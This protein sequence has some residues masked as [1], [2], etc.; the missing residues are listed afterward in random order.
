VLIRHA[1]EEEHRQVTT[2]EIMEVLEA[3][4]LTG[5][6]RDAARLAGCSHHTI[7]TYVAAEKLVGDWT[8][9]RCGAA[10]R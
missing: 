6:L 1:L 4:D 8:G 7:A 10:D 3:F 5:S 9:P 2:G